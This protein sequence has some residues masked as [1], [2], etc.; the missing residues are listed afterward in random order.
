[1]GIQK[2]GAFNYFVVDFSSFS[3]F[4][5]A[6]YDWRIR[7]EKKVKEINIRAR[8]RNGHRSK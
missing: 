1:M 2:S 6:T 3:Y 4:T 5:Q 7:R 8:R